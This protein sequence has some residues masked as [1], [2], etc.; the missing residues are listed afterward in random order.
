M[1]R[2]HHEAGYQPSDCR[3]CA[4]IRA[5]GVR[6]GVQSA[7]LELQGTCD[8]LAL[9][10]LVAQHGAATDVSDV[11][12]VAFL[13]QPPPWALGYI[14]AVVSPVRG[15]T[16]AAAIA[17][18]RGIDGIPWRSC[19]ITSPAL[20]HAGAGV[21]LPRMRTNLGRETGPRHDE[22]GRPG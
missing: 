6:Q 5:C 3:A 15:R 7:R 4:G 16:V 20:A 13:R 22:L 12:L 21:L 9:E 2:W 14:L 11:T 1:G 8:D 17:V 10:M 19:V 18:D